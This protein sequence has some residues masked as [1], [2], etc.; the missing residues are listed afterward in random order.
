[1]KPLL[2]RASWTLVDQGLSAASNLLLSVIV[3]RQ[4]A[5]AG[6]GAFAIAFLT[7]G[8][9]LA[10]ARAT[11]ADPLAISYSGAPVDQWRAAA[12][13]ALGA[14]VLLG[15]VVGV[16]LVII[17]LGLGGATGD[18]LLAVGVSMPGLLAQDICRMAFFSSARAKH[19]AAND[20]LW[21][22]LEF[23]ALAA[24]VGFGVRDVAPFILAWGGSATVAAVVGFLMLGITPHFRGC[25]RW[26][27][28][29]RPLTGYLLAETVLGES[30]AQ[31]GILFVGVMGSAADVGSLRGGQVLLGPL[32]VL[33]TAIAVFGVPEIARRGNWAVRQRQLFCWAL[34]A[35]MT[36]VAIAYGALIL[37][38]PDRF[39]RELFGDTWAGAQTVLLPMCVLY[40][41]VAVGI[42]PGVTLFGLGRARASFGLNL[43]KAP[44]LLVTLTVGIGNAGAVGAAWALAVTESLM[45]PFLIV[46]AMRSMHRAPSAVTGPDT[47]PDGTAVAPVTGTM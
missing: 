23:A 11:I 18:A 6:F 16:A 26:L 32:N 17:G 30:L 27:F 12:K 41:A 20:G 5:A 37:L 19:A 21:I 14:A 40:I 3:A 10:V 33:G 46:T 13:W 35:G 36:A 39:G 47:H 34:S 9:V 7:F 1:M 2:R 28:A 38:L 8:L 22:V 15:A 4:L 44:L 42:G 25:L 29:Q 43:I 24:M 45:L 31:V